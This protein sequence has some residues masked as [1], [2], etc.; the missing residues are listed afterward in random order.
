[1]HWELRALDNRQKVG[2][3]CYLCHE[4]KFVKAETARDP[5]W[6]GRCFDCFQAGGG[7]RPRQD[8][9]DE[10]VAFGSIIHWSE[11][12]LKGRRVP[13][14][15]GICVADGARETKRVI[16]RS[17]IPPK[18]VRQSP[19][20]Q[21]FCRHHSRAEVALHLTRFQSGRGQ[22]HGSE[23]KYENVGAPRKFTDDEAFEAIDRLGSR[24]SVN[25]LA[26]SLN[27]ARV[28]INNWARHQGFATLAELVQARRS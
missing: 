18:K 4:E 23:K 24:V 15:C 20:Y 11:R 2:I 14:T 7:A 3:T 25:Q 13:I 8:L 6:S 21:L 10:P 16:S 17:N 9:K 27:C 12:E 5:N 1:M 19:D 28:T 22:K 26:K